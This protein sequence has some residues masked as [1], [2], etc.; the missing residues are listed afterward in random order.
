MTSQDLDNM[1]YQQ[2]IDMNLPIRWS[3]YKEKNEDISDY[4]LD[5]KAPGNAPD[6]C[7]DVM[8]DYLDNKYG[9]GKGAIVKNGFFEPVSTANAVHEAV[10]A[11]TRYWGIYV[12][13]VEYMPSLRCFLLCMGS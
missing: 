12:E 1:T 9:I 7:Y 2:W 6:G 4:I 10:V 5:L 13:G 3:I 8:F 11:S